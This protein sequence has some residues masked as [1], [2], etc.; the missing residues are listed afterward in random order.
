MSI[1]A[2]ARTVVVDVDVRGQQCR[3]KR[4]ALC[5]LQSDARQ[6]DAGGLRIHPPRIA[7]A[8]QS[9]ILSP[10]LRISD[11]KPRLP[12]FTPTVIDVH[13][14]PNSYG[15]T[16][17]VGDVPFANLALIIRPLRRRWRL[18]HWECGGRAP[19]RLRLI[20]SSNTVG[21]STGKSAGLAPLGFGDDRSKMAFCHISRRRF[22]D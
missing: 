16:P 6:R 5:R 7:F 1:V 22:R 11:A 17:D 8:D 9:I 2:T 19:S 4:S 21:V 13:F 20:A 14:P 3:A 18:A 15:K 10:F 12:S